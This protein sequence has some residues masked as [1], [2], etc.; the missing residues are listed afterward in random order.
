VRG[1]RYIPTIS[2]IAIAFFALLLGLEIA[3]R[4]ALITHA[5]A[6]RPSSFQTFF[7]SIGSITLFTLIVAALV[8]LRSIADRK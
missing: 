4:L 5:F 7:L 3:A 1:Q 8:V 6:I 2:G